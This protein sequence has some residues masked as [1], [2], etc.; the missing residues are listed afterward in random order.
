V[1]RPQQ[2]NVFLVVLGGLA[3]PFL[4]GGAITSIF[5]ALVYRGPL[6][7]PFMHRYFT[8]NPVLFAEAYLFFVGLASL[9]MKLLDVVGQF[10]TLPVLNLGDAPEAGQTPEEAGELLAQLDRLPATARQSYL[11]RRLH[12][13]LQHVLRK[14]SAEGLDNELK[15]LSD[16]DAARQQDSLGLIRIAI[17]ATPMLGFLGTVIGITQ[18]LGY[19]DPK[20]LATDFQST[21]ESLLA[22]LYVKFDTTAVALSL[23]TVMMFLQFLMDRAETQLLSTVDILSNQF[24][25]GR[26]VETGEGS[27]PHLASVER[28]SR[29]VIRSSEGL[30]E[31]QV[32]L[33]QSTVDAAHQHWS[34]LVPAA[35]QQLQG[36]VRAALEGT[37]STF[38]AEMAQAER[39]AADQTHARWEQWQTALLENARQLQAQQREMSRQS[40]LLAQVVQATGQVIGLERTLNENL[41]AL[42]GS[43]NFEDMVLSLN[44]AIHLLTAR[45]G[46]VVPGMS[47]VE[48]VEPRSKGRAA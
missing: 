32:A 46:G 31:R 45:L 3:W 6:N 24:L 44:A 34:E 21:M 33:W 17:W 27:D 29:A 42:S 35:G 20:L 28:M 23:S 39:Q 25:V 12:D 40:E 47:Q 26:F 9:S 13:T 16:L 38:A 1:S 43:K 7:V 2:R 4:I 19:L 41:K 11:G 30:L 8:A 18:A 14:K 22:G 48:L 36:S 5:Y 10:I 37:L 15:Y